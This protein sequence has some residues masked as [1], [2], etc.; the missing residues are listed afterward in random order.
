MEDL[1]KRREVMVAETRAKA[2]RT[3]KTM[4]AAQISLR[5]RVTT[6]TKV[7][8]KVTRMMRTTGRMKATTK[9]RRRMRTARIRKDLLMEFHFPKRKFDEETKE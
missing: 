1:A 9:M 3:K 8:T 4:K 2:I 6:R 7:S 5:S